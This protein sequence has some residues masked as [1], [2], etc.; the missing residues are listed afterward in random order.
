MGNVGDTGRHSWWH[1]LWLCAVLVLC[2]GPAMA[3]GAELVLQRLQGDAPPVAQLRAGAADGHL[4]PPVDAVRASRGAAGWW[5]VTSPTPIGAG[6]QPRLLLRSPYLNRVQAWVPGRDAPQELALYGDHADSRYSH[7]A[8]VAELP[9]GIPAG[10]AVWLHVQAGSTLPMQ[11]AVE[12]LAEVHRDDL[13]FVAWRAF[14]LSV[15]CVLAL[16]A[17]AFRFGTGD[18]SFAWFAAMLVFAVLYLL[19]LGGDARL[20]PGA[21]TV[22]GSSTR[23]NRVFGGLGVV[24]SNLFQRSYLDLRG[25]LPRLDRALWVGTALAAF[26][27]VGS[28]ASDAPVLASAG[29]LG[30]VLSSV[31]LFV[32][33]TRLAFRGDRAGLVVMASWLPLMVFTLLMATQMMGLWDGTRWLHEGLAASFALAGLLLT[34]GLA[35]KLLEL[36]RD[37]D[38]ASALARAD[39]LTGMLNRTGI[40][41]ALRKVM[42]SAGT[43]GAPMSIAFVDVDNFKPVNDEHGHGIGDQCL[44]IVSQRIRSQLRGG[45]IIGRF[46]G[47][48]FLVVLPQT[49]LDVALAVAGRM[50]A[51]VNSRPLTIDDLH[52]PGSLSIGVAERAPGESAQALVERADAALYASKEMGRNRV[53]AA[54]APGSPPATA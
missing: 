9:E 51:S 24:C 37:R 36:R 15:L 10:S 23:A 31:L 21:E 49:R 27:G 29:N 53:T 42:R 25:K 54:R 38:Q 40:E 43:S 52:L 39:E 16:L 13:A 48:E 19:S 41:E 6:D 45:D 35:D 18:A 2:A 26:A 47:D 44:R 22:F 12:P 20:L 17:F 50:L 28:L 3:A 14:V 46:G 7:R 8:L 34:I 32:G 30:L 5:R 1:G 11:V 4:G 33:S